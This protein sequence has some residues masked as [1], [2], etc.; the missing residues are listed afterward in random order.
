MGDLWGVEAGSRRA[1]RQAAALF[2]LSGVL[3]IV[4]LPTHPGHGWVLVGIVA[5]DFATA[6]VA[7][8]LSRNRR[9]RPVVALLG[10]PGFII[11]GVSTWA[12]GGLATGTGPFFVLMFAWL[13]LNFSERVVLGHV[14]LATL[15]YAVPL[16]ISGAPVEVVG[17]TLVLVPIAMAVG[18]IITGRVRQLGAA[19]EE[20]AQEERWRAALMA[21]L[22]HDVRT[23]LTMIQ[24]ALELVTDDEELHPDHRWLLNGAARQADRIARMSAT[25]LDVERVEGGR[26][27]LSRKRFRLAGAVRPLLD[28]LGATEVR[29]DVDPDLE[30]DAD[31]DRLE[32]V[33]ANL[34]GN[35][36]RH[37]SPPVALTAHRD[38]GF[39]TIEVCDHGNGIDSTL[40]GVLFERFPTGA[41]KQGS[42]GLGLWS[43]KLLVEAHGGP[44]AYR[45]GNPGAV[46]S[47]RLPAMQPPSV[48]EP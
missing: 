6:A 13:G 20:M 45:R 11:L 42:V 29:I 34:V 10:I 40:A 4:A 46:F 33:I 28:L 27:R 30:V 9:R 35:A 44:L 17:S 19:R 18:L 47:V 36:L 7:L 39:V 23:P 38:D 31:P 5:G 41:D 12:F 21:S 15:T 16:V 14:P 32:Q 26:L 37:G 22:A 25:L 48:V 3:G 8:G 24:G 43:T 1:A 2:G